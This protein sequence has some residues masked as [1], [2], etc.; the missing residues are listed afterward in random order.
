[1]LYAPLEG[2]RRVE[3]T[4][5]RTKVDW[6]EVV[7]KLVDEDY[8]CHKAVTLAGRSSCDIW[9][10]TP[11]GA[12]AID[13]LEIKPWIEA[14]RQRAFPTGAP[15]TGRHH[16]GGEGRGG[17]AGWALPPRATAAVEG[18]ISPARNNMATDGTPDYGPLWY[19][20]FRRDGT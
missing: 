5:R 8:A 17:Q 3:V 19:A 15:A 11:S 12:A 18:H 6:A 20:T 7:R 4:D 16:P 10:P 13:V 14:S 2:W 1:M 9:N